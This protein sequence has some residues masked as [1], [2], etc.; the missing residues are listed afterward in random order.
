MRNLILFAGM[1]CLLSGCGGGGSEVTGK[2]TLDDG[3]A[4]PRGAV[5]LRNDA[6]SFQGAIQSD[7][8]YTI[9]DVPNGDYSVAVAGVMDK[10]GDSEEGMAFDQETGE[11]I[12][13]AVEP[14][15]SLIK[16]EYSF[17]DKSGLTLTVPG[18]NYDLKLDR[19]GA[20]EAPAG[21]GSS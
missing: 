14:P 18:G 10:E 11:Y 12:E 4:A 1:A 17:P 13:S 7:G 21:D 3:S 6:G 2:V 20:A 5:T 19:A 15:K 16:A 9:E 8:T